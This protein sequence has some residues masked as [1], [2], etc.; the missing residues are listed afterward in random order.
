M[1]S[2]VG[3]VDDGRTDT[4]KRPARIVALAAI[5][6][7][8]AI[9]A[10]AA[11]RGEGDPHD[12]GEPHDDAAVTLPRVPTTDIDRS[13]ADAYRWETLP[14]G[15]GGFVTG[16]V[17]A[18]G[19]DG[20]SVVYAR[21]DVGGAYRWDPTTAEWT[22]LLRSGSLRDGRFEPPD[23]SV[24]AIAVAPSAADV[25]AVA[26]GDGFNP[27]GPADEEGPFGRVLW[28]TDGGSTWD[29][30]GHRWNIAAD[31]GYPNGREQLAIDPG[32]PTRALLGTQRDGLWHT[33][34]SGESWQRVPD[35]QV[36]PGPGRE[37]ENIPGVSSVSYVPSDDGRSVAVVG[38]NGDG[39]YVSDD[40]ATWTR[41][42]ELDDGEFAANASEAGDG[43]VIST[44]TPGRSEARLLRLSGLASGPIDG[45]S[46]SELVTPQPAAAWVLAVSP[47]PDGTIALSDEAMR[48]GHFWTSRDGGS[49]WRTHDVD[50]EAP[51]VPWLGATDLDQWMSAGRL[52]FDPVDTDTLWFAEGMGVWTTEDLSDDVVT[53]TSVAAGI[54]ELVISDVV[55]PPG[56]VPI[57]TA[58]DRQGF[59]IVDVRRR[60]DRTLVDER[61]ASG[62]G[63]DY[64][65]GAPERLAWIGAQSNLHA[66]EARA[67]GAT[68][69]DGGETW[70]E[71]GGLDPEMF[72]GE[73]AVSATD[74][75]SIVW[76]PAKRGDLSASA[77]YTSGD[78]G[79]SWQKV[80]MPGGLDQYH[81]NFWWFGRRALAA[82]RVDGRFYLMSDHGRLDVS[83]D[84]RTWHTAPHAPPCRV[85]SDCHVFG[86]LRAEPGRAGRL[87]ATTGRSGLFRSDD[88]GASP[89]QQVGHFDGARAFGFG[90][91][92]GGSEHPTVYL[93]GW[94][95]DQE[96]PALWRSTDDGATWDLVAE[97]PGGIAA[98]IHVV[99]G[100]P[101]IPGRV[102]VGFTGV[103][104][105]Y[106]DDPDAR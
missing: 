63:V 89:W 48:D 15:G 13:L 60:P 66:S 98:G 57:V 6:G 44:T 59:R 16:I 54:E 56:G 11:T 46:V 52:M 28:S 69:T 31:E 102:Y 12:P 2:D 53:W 77:L 92:I 75:D 10:V 64:S 65:A 22:Q 68:S 79:R 17:S 18:V 93:Y 41:V 76:L 99:A 38:V 95:Q 90:A 61:F 33:A 70:R 85:T 84:G 72:G 27:I 30:S 43:L 42:A 50:I 81:Q 74:P 26:V 34:D 62:A 47:G 35:D 71:M 58:A 23:Y 105:V 78:F 4:T 9:A 37:G 5:A 25:V 103:S 101:N 83:D 20:A 36:P 86:Q 32:D 104:V 94:A 40:V 80:P 1:C 100:D 45:I 55:V 19:D 14:I 39:I 8:A 21:T 96:R 91:P 7:V 67:R 97:H 29:D 73:V 106:G 3:V 82:D 24:A 87:W 88:A 49:S 51:T